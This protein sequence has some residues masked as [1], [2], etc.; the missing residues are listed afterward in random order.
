L[1]AGLIV[2]GV[3]GEFTVPLRAIAPEEVSGEAHA[4]MSIGAS[5]E[6]STAR[7]AGG[8]AAGL[9]PLILLAVRSNFTEEALR[10]V[11]PL[12]GDQA[13]VVSL[14]NGINEELIASTIGAERTIGAIVGWGA[15]YVA[16]GHVSQTSEGD[17]VIGRLDG[18]V[19]TDLRRAAA[20]LEKVAPVR[21]SENI[22]GDL[23]AKLIINCVTV[24]GAVAGVTTGDL[25]APAENKRVLLALMG[26][27]IDTAT[28]AGV[29]LEKFEG[30]VDPMMF[31]TSDQEG[32]KTCFAIMDLM[33]LRF[34]Q[35]KS[36]TL[37]DLQAGRATEID[38][39]TGYVV[40]KA[41]ERG[42]AVPINET[43]LRQLREIGRGERAMGQRNLEELGSLVPRDLPW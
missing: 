41:Q 10:A 40:G 13:Q 32:A 30:L 25:L 42:L 39:V 21:L 37:S 1:K 26:E 29:R 8:S 38:F 33:A 9:P 43:A 36:V 31:K 14:Q 12:L 11:L 6:G 4:G 27:A 22:L 19:D 18:R 17:F 20:T 23:W 7:S 28:A 5:A 15:T 24:V 16:P 35:V 2:D 3:K 34:G